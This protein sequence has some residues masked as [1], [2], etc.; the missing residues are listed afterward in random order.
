[1][2]CFAFALA[3]CVLTMF[4]RYSFWK[5]SFP[6]EVRS[7]PRV[8]H[9]FAAGLQ[10]MNN[11]MDLGPDAPRQLKKPEFKPFGGASLAA[12]PETAKKARP[13]HPTAEI[14]FRSI[15]EDFAAQH[16]LLFIPT[17]KTHERSRMP[18]YKVSPNVDGKGGITAYILDDA[19]WTADGGGEDYR[20][21]GLEDMVLRATKGTK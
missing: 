6:E 10:L 2:V 17:G 15:V 7:M 18:L 4:H 14:T 20:A 21:I 16:N 19:V 13:A 1:M 5:S 11:A 8:E 9:G 12:A 3:D